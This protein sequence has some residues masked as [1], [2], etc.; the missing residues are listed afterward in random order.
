MR[1]QRLSAAL[2]VLF[3]LGLPLGASSTADNAT[4][5]VVDATAGKIKG[6]LLDEASGLRAYRG[7]P[8]AAAPV[9]DLRWKA[10]QPAAK[11]AGE[12]DATRF[13]NI[14]PQ[15]PL[16]AM[17]TGEPLPD[18][19]EDCL[20]LNVWTNAEPGAKRPVMVW[21]H[22]GGLTLGWSN[23]AQYEGSE[24]AKRGVVL[25]SV[26][27]RLGPLGYLAHPALT[28]ES[29]TSG[30][31][32]FLDQLA[33]LEWVQA[34]IEAFGGDP[35]N[36]TIFGESAGGTSVHALVASPQA[37]GLFHKAIAQ[38]PWLTET[39]IAHATKSTELVTSNESQGVAFIAKAAGKE[40][41]TLDEMRQI[42]ASQLVQSSAQ[43]YQVAMTTG[44]SFMPESSEARFR[45]GSYNRVPMIVGTNRNE[46]TMFMAS[47]PL[48]TRQAFEGLI[49]ASFKAEAP[50]I[51]A[52]YP[53]S[54]DDE[55]KTQVD[56]YITDAWFLRGSRNM[57][58]G[59]SQAG[60]PVYQY[61]FVRPSPAN[62]AWGAH[63]AAELG[64]VFNT[65][66]EEGY[67]KVDAGI[68]D[69]MIR[70]WVQFATT[71]D[72]NVEGLPSWPAYDAGS[73]QH[74][75]IGE[76]MVVRSRLGQER[77]D[78]LQATLDAFE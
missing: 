38:S 7:I 77:N 26:N 49:A 69:A 59:A 15:L 64:Y 58:N 36:V 21:I 76:E 56:Q 60:S 57:L 22:G 35:G 47:M 41:A 61:H 53:S 16:L 20:F 73:Q 23:Q 46:G 70:Y 66:P 10:P 27:Y 32:G 30:N 9:G 24:M 45:S 13:G 75:E 63:H 5:V 19:S 71:G 33:A 55:L 54:S 25:V 67:E 11:W 8:F 42:P 6:E 44:N 17:M 51:A 52:L 50:K 31:Y 3:L 39:N 18:S 72:P 68:A 65:L 12:L 43:G 37:E 2:T 28:Q 14:C 40:G 4:A 74:L 29:G 1:T 48:G 62:P 34:N 78:T